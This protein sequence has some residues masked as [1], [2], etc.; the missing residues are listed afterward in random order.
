MSLSH[1]PQTST[2]SAWKYS[3]P[4]A[5]VLRKQLLLERKA[6]QVLHYYFQMDS[7]S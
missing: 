1:K 3:A 4:G 5:A 6:N 2:V 7:S